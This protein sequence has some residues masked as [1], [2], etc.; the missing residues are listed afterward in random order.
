MHG[1][2]GL[3]VPALINS[4]TSAAGTK[5][6]SLARVPANQAIPLMKHSQV[7]GTFHAVDCINYY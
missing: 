6:K 7:W 2:A 3:M 5:P 4:G 1:R